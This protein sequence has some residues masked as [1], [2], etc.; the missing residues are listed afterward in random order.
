MFAHIYNFI[1]VSVFG[2]GETYS[3][4]LV[5]MVLE[6]VN[7]SMLAGLKARG[8]RAHGRVYTRRDSHELDELI[9]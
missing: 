5:E 4:E 2:R 7:V 6:R 9:E 8:G 1:A 3:H